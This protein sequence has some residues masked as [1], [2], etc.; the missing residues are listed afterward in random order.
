M[1]NSSQ[2]NAIAVR[3]ESRDFIGILKGTVELVQSLFYMLNEPSAIAWSV[4]PR[5]TTHLGAS[6]VPPSNP[7]NDR[8]AR[9]QIK[10]AFE[11][12][13]AHEL[14]HV[15]NGHLQLGSIGHSG[16]IA[17]LGADETKAPGSKA[18]LQNQALEMD[19]DV[20]A[21][22]QGLHNINVALQELDC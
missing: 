1:I 6:V 7:S 2:L 9:I 13:I 10:F 22:T 15:R 18:I 5:D 14:A 17:E 19:A 8:I 3:Q 16:Q 12:L 20:F 21:V 11:F 4:L